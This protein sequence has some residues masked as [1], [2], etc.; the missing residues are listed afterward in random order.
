ML[1][2]GALREVDAVPEE[3]ERREEGP[4]EGALREVDAVPEEA[5]RREEGPREGALRE[6]DAVAAE[7]GT[8]RAWLHLHA[9][10]SFA[11]PCFFAERHLRFYV[12]VERLDQPRA[13]RTAPGGSHVRV[14]KPAHVSLM[15]G[16]RYYRS[17][18]SSLLR[19]SGC[20]H[21]Q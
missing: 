20:I 17:P 16:C 11:I 4:W 13:T 5:E 15:S 21:S 2:A 3:A 12:C 1:T 19:N 18:L 10:I 7:E 14:A 9:E 6:V 8:A